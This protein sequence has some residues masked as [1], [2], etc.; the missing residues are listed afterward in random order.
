MRTATASLV[1]LLVAW[2]SAVFPI[3]STTSMEALFLSNTLSK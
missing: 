3:S 2:I 1:V